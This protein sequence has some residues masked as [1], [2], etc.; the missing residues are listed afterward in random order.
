MEL[1]RGVA[2]L[3]RQVQDDAREAID[4]DGF[5]QVF[6]EPGLEGSLAPVG[7]G[8]RGQ[9]DCRNAR[10]TEKAAP[11]PLPA[12]SARTVPPCSS[13][14]CRTMDRPRPSPPNC[15]ALECSCW[16]NRLKT[17]GRKLGSIAIPVSLTR[18]NA[19]C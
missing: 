9:C 17:K 18:R 5:F 19:S 7:A 4:V 14:M 13:T 15:R 11:L 8:R 6:L 3:P 16:V 2:P 10:L 1:P 12:L